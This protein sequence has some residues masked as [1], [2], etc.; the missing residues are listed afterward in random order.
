MA[1]KPFGPWPLFSFLILYTVGITPWM[2]DQTVTRPLPTQTQNK[3]TQTSMA[4]VRFEPTIPLFERAKTVHAL[5]C[6]VTEIGSFV[7]FYL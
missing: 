2:W 3:R 4:V 7:T 5:N 1:L 6:A